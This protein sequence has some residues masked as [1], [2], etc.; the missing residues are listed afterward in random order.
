MHAHIKVLHNVR[1][2]GLPRLALLLGLPDATNYRDPAVNCIG[3]LGSALCIGFALNREQA[4]KSTNIKENVA[5]R[6]RISHQCRAM[7]GNILTQI[8]QFRNVLRFTASVVNKDYHDKVMISR[9]A[10]TA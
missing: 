6:R 2:S 10:R 5:S 4:I 7:V 8:V 3:C 1:N 9:L